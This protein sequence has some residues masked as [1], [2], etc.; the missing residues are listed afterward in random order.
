MNR[1]HHF[2]AIVYGPCMHTL[3]TSNARWAGAEGAGAGAACGDGATG[4][5]RDPHG[6]RG[7]DECGGE[8]SGGMRVGGAVTTALDLNL[9]SSAVALTLPLTL[10]ASL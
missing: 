2:Q 4:A 10:A 1:T 8:G 7:G 9:S 6:E 3:E 5:G